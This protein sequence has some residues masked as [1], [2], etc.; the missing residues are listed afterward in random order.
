LESDPLVIYRQSIRDEESRTGEA[1]TR[2]YDVGREEALKD[3]EVSKVFAAHLE[4]L[5]QQTDIFMDALIKSVSRMPYGIRYI[6]KHLGMEL[7]KKFPVKSAEDEGRVWKVIGN[8]VY[9]RYMNPAIVAPEGFDVI[10]QIISPTQ[11][12]NLAEISKLLQQ[13]SVGRLYDSDIAY[14]S[15]LNDYIMKSYEKMTA[16]FKEVV[17]VPEA[18]DFFHMSDLSDLSMT[19]KPVVYITPQEIFNTH[20]FILDALNDIAPD[21]DDVLK[22]LMDQ[23]GSPPKSAVTVEYYGGP[24]NE[25]E[26]GEEKPAIEG[27]RG[28]NFIDVIKSCN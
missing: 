19:N 14:L 1:S 21:Q 26:T 25:E 8:L 28:K 9:Y 3:P 22:K 11:R 4:K 20:K 23:L 6:A 2:P 27:L 18:E 13:V 24:K 10:E 5:K 17:N 7:R 12:K 15:C 16:Y